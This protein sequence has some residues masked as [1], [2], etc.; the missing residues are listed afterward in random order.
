MVDG[1]LKSLKPSMRE[2]KHYLLLK[3]DFSKDDAEKAILDYIGVLG[4]AKAAPVWISGKILAVNRKYVDNVKASFAF[5]GEK[6]EV[7]KVSG[8]IKGLRGKIKN[9]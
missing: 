8:T 2:K 3:G 7:I 1:K 9:S 4:Y 5:S 6:I